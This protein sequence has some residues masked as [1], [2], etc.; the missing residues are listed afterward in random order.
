MESTTIR[1]AGVWRRLGAALI[2]GMILALA[3]YILMH[4]L[5]FSVVSDVTLLLFIFGLNICYGILMVQKYGATVGKMMLDV[6]VRTLDM[7]PVGLKESVLRYSVNIA[8]GAVNTCLTI[9]VAISVPPGDGVSWAERVTVFTKTPAG[10]VM[11]YFAFLPML[12]ALV[13][14]GGL[15]ADKR[16]RAIHDY[17]AGTLVIVQK[18]EKT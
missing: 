16:K 3:G 2:D 10:T 13:L 12:W 8:M 18:S 6:Q 11:T 5:G 15:I 4:G 7:R 17:I 9:A 14:L 1:Y